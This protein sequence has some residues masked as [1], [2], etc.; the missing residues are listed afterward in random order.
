[1]AR[2]IGRSVIKYAPFLDVKSKQC[3][4][5]VVGIG[6]KLQLYS[7]GMPLAAHYHRF[8]QAGNLACGT[9]DM[10]GDGG[11]DSFEVIAS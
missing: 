9:F 6:G 5:T 7:V 3:A 4:Q 11:G 1:M 10:Q 8:C 2:P